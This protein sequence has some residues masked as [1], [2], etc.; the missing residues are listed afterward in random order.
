[1]LN[2]QKFDVPSKETYK[3]E[4]M[5]LAAA[6]TDHPELGRR[7]ILVAGTNGKG[8]TCT[9]LTHLFQSAGFKV[10]TYSSPHV[11]ERGERIR[12]NGKPLSEFELLSYEKRYKRILEP[13]TY[14]ERMTMLA[15]LI[16]RDKRVDLQ[17]LEVGMG[18][19]LDAT[20]ISSPDIGVITTIDYDH[21]E[22][23]GASLSK[24]AYEKAGIMR[25]RR[26]VF[27]VKQR[28]QARASL[29]KHA[30]KIGAY[31]FESS[32][33]M[34]A[35]KIEAEIK[36]IE[37][38]RG[39][40][41]AENAR[42][43]VSVFLYAMEIWEFGGSAAQTVKA[44]RGD[45]WPARIQILRKSPVFI[46]DGAHNPNAIENLC[47]YLKQKKFSKKFT[48]VFGAMDDKPVEQMCRQLKPWAQ[49][50]YCPTFYPEREMPPEVLAQVWKKIGSKKSEVDT[51]TLLP[52]LIRKLW[53]RREPVLVAGS[54]YLAGAV[55]AE[56]KKQNG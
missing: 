29:Q 19:R 26:P 35:P 16:F 1:M 2:F 48:L 40:P 5:R 23:L 54:F 27:V 41:Q 37:K 22:V 51:A 47:H 30:K 15:F 3:L 14:F 50:I 24:I 43:A 25:K 55:L 4:K 12:I 44:L 20:N 33:F 49:K 52:E 18:G 32:P 45:L 6:L 7:T 11:V 39:V 9:Y 21:Q 17:V 34:M 31:L 53:S 13:L 38:V 46:I 36:R 56:L 8:S 10:G 42:A 28:P